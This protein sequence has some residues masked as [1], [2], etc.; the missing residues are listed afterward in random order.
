MALLEILAENSIFEEIW[1]INDF[2]FLAD[3]TDERLS[4]YLELDIFI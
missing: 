4:N 2:K 1:V 3:C